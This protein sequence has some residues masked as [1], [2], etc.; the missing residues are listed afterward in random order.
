MHPRSSLSTLTRTGAV[1]ALAAFLVAAG[2]SEPDP[3]LHGNPP[4]VPAEAM[5]TGTVELEGQAHDFEVV[6]CAFGP[7]ETGNPQVEF[8]L[9]GEN[10]ETGLTVDVSRVDMSDAG[11][12]YQDVV[13]FLV[14]DPL[15]PDEAVEATRQGDA[16]GA[17]GAS[18]FLSLQGDQVTAE[19]LT[20]VA[21]A[22]PEAGNELEGS[23]QATCP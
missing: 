3:N 12:G 11:M 13:L 14:G 5:A 15:N 2:P 20:F 18:E 19:D 8:S 16:P 4:A 6:H 23:F 21:V 7:E 17:E 1:A 10:Q 22:G 9:Q